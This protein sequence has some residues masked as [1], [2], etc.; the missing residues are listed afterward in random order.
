[1]EKVIKR[2]LSVSH[3]YG[4]GSGSGYG[5]VSGYGYGDGYGLKK[6]GE[7]TVYNIDGVQT[8]IYSVHGIYAKGAIVNSDL[9]LTPC[10]VAKV[11]DCFAHGETLQKAVADARVKALQNTSIEERIDTFVSLYADPNQKAAG[12]EFFNWHNILTGSCEQG[13]LQFCKDNDIDINADY[14]PMEF[15]N[16]CKDAYGGEIIKQVIEKYN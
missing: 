8:L 11:D 12:K 2:F 6:Y 7:H 10:F 4:Y 15:L 3:G 9:T 1:M 13:R 5:Y 14:T 16:L